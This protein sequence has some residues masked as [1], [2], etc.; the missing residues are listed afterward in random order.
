MGR[1]AVKR[2]F[3]L[4]ATVLTICAV[5][6]L[7]ALG[8]WQVQRLQWKNN[9]I[10]QME[11]ARAAGP[12][13]VAFAG[14]KGDAPLYARLRGR[15]GAVT[16]HVGPR[17][18]KGEVGS[19]VF[20][21]IAMDGGAVL[22]NRGW[23]PQGQEKNVKP[24]EGEVS[25]TGLLRLPERGNPFTPPNDPVK[26][27]WFRADPAQMAQAAG[28][29]E[30]AALIMHVENEAP[31]SPSLQPVRATP[32]ASLPNDHLQYAVFWFAMAGVLLVIYYLRFW[33]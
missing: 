9:L 25:V 4:L 16:F 18:Y 11:A 23:V 14:I 27:E 19:Y 1:S 30:I 21:P 12:K 17:T 31:E 29:G 7:C 28:I 5:V 33:R 10:A 24:P 20:A 32:Q 22:V 26:N 3:P 15:Y 2:Q 6:V 8:S 13:D